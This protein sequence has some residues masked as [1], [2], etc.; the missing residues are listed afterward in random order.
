MNLVF[1]YRITERIVSTKLKNLKKPTY[2]QK[3]RISKA[4]LNANEYFVKEDNDKVMILIH[5][6]TGESKCLEK[7]KK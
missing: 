1:N 7:K 2:D 6:V 5:K 3:Q 4:K